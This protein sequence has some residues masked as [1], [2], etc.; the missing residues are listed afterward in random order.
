[1]FKFGC[2][3]LVD[4]SKYVGVPV[5]RVNAVAFCCGDE[6]E[7]C[8]DSLGTSVRA[9]EEAVFPY[10][11]PAFDCPF[12]RI[13]IDGDVRIF[14]ETGQRTPVLKRVIYSF[15]EFV[16]WREVHL[17]ADDNFPQLFD[18]RFRFSATD[19]QSKRWRTVFDLPLD[20]VEFAVNIE[21][22]LANLVFGELI[23]EI[24]TPGVGMATSLRSCAA[25]EQSVEAASSISLNDSSKVF[26]EVQIFVE[27]EIGG[28]IEH[29]DR[30]LRVT[31]VYSN[32]SFSNI[33]FVLA[34]LDL[35]GRIVR[36]D[37]LGLKQLCFLKIVEQTQGVGGSL[38][39]VTLSGTRDGDILSCEDFFLPII[40][41]TI[42]ELADDDFCKEARSSVASW[43]RR[44]GF[45]RG[46]DVMLT[47]R[48]SAGFLAMSEHFQ[49]GA[50]HFKLISNQITYEDSLDR[51]IW[52]DSVL[53]FDSMGDLYMRQMLGI[54]QNVFD[55]R[56]FVRLSGWFRLRA[57]ESGAWIVFFSLFPVVALIAFFRLCNEDIE[58]S[59]QIVE[60][61]AEVLISLCRLLQQNLKFLNET[62]KPR[63]FS[64]GALMR[65]SQSQQFLVFILRH[66][67]PYV[68]S[69]TRIP[70]QLIM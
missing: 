22:S 61:F 34:V 4:A 15:H 55:A 16:S 19:G 45:F 29:G 70:L 1:M 66:V 62:G 58:F 52:T 32:L 21:N 30:V 38:H 46:H 36:L 56:S 2:F 69:H 68:V 64:E 42:V 39:P 28:E 40:W 27:G 35:Y 3:H 20:C 47:F 13:I 12:R 8:R 51:A 50:H 10:K 67:A 53:W 65:L 5:Y 18:E 54:F 24:S 37:Y 60:Q 7:V 14:E 31:Y 17:G 11:D 59:L 63:Y 9:C 33:V 25:F 6:R 44:A 41:Q 26:K 57:A 48:A 43:N 23:F 49:T